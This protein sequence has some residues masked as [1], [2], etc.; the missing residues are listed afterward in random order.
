MTETAHDRLLPIRTVIQMVGFATP[1]IYRKMADG[2]FP[3]PVKIRNAARWSE[4]DIVE[5]IEAQKA[6]CQHAA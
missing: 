5:W 1:T 3:R 6:R 2:E 4:R